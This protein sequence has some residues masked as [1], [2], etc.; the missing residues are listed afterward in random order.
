L[1]FTAYATA[2]KHTFLQK[3][4]GSVTVLQRPARRYTFAP[5]FTS[6]PV[7]SDPSQIVVS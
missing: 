2:K 3:F 1:L 6:Y 7:S 4:H 5:P